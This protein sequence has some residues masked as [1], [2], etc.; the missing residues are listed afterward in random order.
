MTSPFAP[1]LGTNYCP[2]DDEI[3][4][5]KDLLL[6]PTL[7]LGRLDGEIVKL[8]KEI[9]KLLEERNNLHTYVEAHK[10]LLSPVR[11]VPPDIIQEIF[12]ACLP[13]H[14]NCVMSAQEAPVL[15]GRICSFWRTISL[16]TP[17]I[18]SRLHV[19][20]PTLPDNGSWTLG[21]PSH[22][23]KLAQ[24]AE[25]T[26][27]WLGRSGRCPL[28]ISFRGRRDYGGSAGPSVDSLL[29]A[30]IPFA[31]RW[32]HIQF[33]L[34]QADLAPVFHLTETDL[35]ML[36][37]VALV[38]LD[39]EFLPAPRLR[40][41]RDLRGM[42]HGAR[43]SGF[44]VSHFIVNAAQ[45]PLRWDQLTVLSIFSMISNSMKSGEALEL[46][47]RC[48]R[49]RSCTLK[50]DDGLDAT[51]IG[52]HEI[53]ENKCL[54]TLD[55]FCGPTS[56]PGPL[57]D[58]LSLPELRDFTLR[59]IFSPDGQK[60]VPD[61]SLARHCAVWMHLEH[62]HIESH[63][64]LETSTSMIETFLSF[65]PT[66]MRLKID[67]STRYTNGWDPS[68]LPDDEV[69]AVLTPNHGR[70]AALCPVLQELIIS[71]CSAISDTALLRF[72]DAR[73]QLGPS[74]ALK[75]VKIQFGRKVQ[76]DIIPSVQPFIDTGLDVSLQ[77]YPLGP[78]FSPWE[79]LVDDPYNLTHLP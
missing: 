15:L 4:A 27:V 54:Q 39:S 79:G 5:I 67:V 13:S 3:I 64:F 16:S 29:Q 11:R 57:L 6:E 26:K 70:P 25:T 31:A 37:T 55:L 42:L 41:A 65:P 59:R 7:R 22:E 52:T 71:N 74:P 33:T 72:I 20:E 32:Q 10:A 23:E 2:R 53:L 49:L 56:A 47:S 63:L 77:Y 69:L 38:R 50:L 68:D 60:Q 17:R 58:H 73:M 43:L 12:L 9:D 19:V 40:L 48:P 51:W 34:R 44:S 76:L 46:I 30:L 61:V 24:R 66:L 36:S 28:S 45:L 62:L 78:Q 35:P 14:R 8:Q 21:S 75:L 1:Q 18:W